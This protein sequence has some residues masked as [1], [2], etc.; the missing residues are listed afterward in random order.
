MVGVL[1]AG[2][3]A[4]NSE[5]PWE[6]EMVQSHFQVHH[7]LVRDVPRDSHQSPW[8]LGGMS[9]SVGGG[10]SVADTALNNSPTHSCTHSL[11]H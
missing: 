1:L 11:T 4:A 5:P 9:D 7:Q 10:A 6:L 8:I 2:F 3:E